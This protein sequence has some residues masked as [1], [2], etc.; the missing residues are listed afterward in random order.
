[1]PAS[2]RPWRKALD[3]LHAAGWP[4]KDI[5]LVLHISVGT[6][7]RALGVRPGERASPPYGTCSHPVGKLWCD[8][9][10]AGGRA[11]CDEHYLP[12]WPS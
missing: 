7:H 2:T 3:V 4:P 5:A 8:R 12:W 9:P 10:V 11:F 6:V 1:M